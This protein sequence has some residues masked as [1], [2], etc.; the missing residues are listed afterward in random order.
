MRASE[1]ILILISDFELGVFLCECCFYSGLINGIWGQAGISF[2][3]RKLLEED[4]IR[5]FFSTKF[6][7]ILS[8]SIDEGKR[9]ISFKEIQIL[10]SFYLKMLQ[11]LKNNLIHKFL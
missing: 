2:W 9:L 3:K 7:L 6:S 8:L 1:N 4:D 5:Y 11:Y 10:K